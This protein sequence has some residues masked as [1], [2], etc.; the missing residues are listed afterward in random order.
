ML[1]VAEQKYKE[2][3]ID[4]MSKARQLFSNPNKLER[5]KITCRAF[6]RCMSIKYCDSELVD[7][8]HPSFDITFRDA[9]FEITEVLGERKRDSEL[10][11]SETKYKNASSSQEL[12]VP[13]GNPE[14]ILFS[15]MVQAVSARLGEK[16]RKRKQKG[17]KDI[18]ALVC[19]M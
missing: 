16:F 12:L 17:C 11:K 6:L 14:P 18:D 4:A 7:P 5:E 2:S 15:K 8:G 9:K 19:M 1:S 3:M 10:K 13:L